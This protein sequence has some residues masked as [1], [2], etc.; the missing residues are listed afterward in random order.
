MSDTTSGRRWA[1]GIAT[2]VAAVLVVAVAGAIADVWTLESRPG[3]GSSSSTSPAREVTRPWALVPF[4]MLTVWMAV[5]LWRPPTDGPQQAKPV[6][7]VALLVVVLLAVA[8]L[9]VS[10]A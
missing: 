10:I 3:R 1:A 2:A 7:T 8:L 6:R 9:P 5:V 4:T